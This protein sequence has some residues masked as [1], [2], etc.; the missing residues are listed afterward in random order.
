MNFIK[1][2]ILTQTVIFIWYWIIFYKKYFD[3]YY[4]KLENSKNT[5]YICYQTLYFN[6]KLF[7]IKF[8]VK[9]VC[10]IYLHEI[11]N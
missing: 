2:I 3:S 5:W 7:D 8:N 9:V 6:V 10:N 11:Q 4:M 1:L